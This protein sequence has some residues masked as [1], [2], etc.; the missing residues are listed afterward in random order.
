MPVRHFMVFPLTKSPFTSIPVRLHPHELPGLELCPRALFARPGDPSPATALA[1]APS[2]TVM[3][4]WLSTRTEVTR[5]SL[6]KEKVGR[7]RRTD[8]H[9]VV[10]EI[11][12]VERESLRT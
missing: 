12:W 1:V 4:S 3:A 8:D 9:R 10:C 6:R 2:L 7:G 5:L 11:R